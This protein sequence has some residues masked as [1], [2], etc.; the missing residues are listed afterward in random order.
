MAYKKSFPYEIG[1]LGPRD[2]NESLHNIGIVIRVFSDIEHCLS[3]I[4]MSELEI[5]EVQNLILL[6]RMSI[7]AK[8]GKVESL[9]TTDGRGKDFKTVFDSDFYGYLN[10]RNILAHGFYLGT[11][12]DEDKTT[13]MFRTVDLKELEG[14]HGPITEVAGLSD[15][16]ISVAAKE[17]VEYA[18]KIIEH[19]G[20]RP[21]LEKSLQQALVRRKQARKPRKKS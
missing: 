17:T 10:V 3:L 16:S 14:D 2:L 18:N 12:Q 21:S 13:H 6:G 11:M 15:G 8:L 20:L 9:M 19:Y 4:L 5:S 1:D 7:S